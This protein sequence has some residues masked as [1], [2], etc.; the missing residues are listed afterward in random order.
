MCED[1]GIISL[2]SIEKLINMRE[3]QLYLEKHNNKIWQGKNKKWY[4]YVGDRKLIKRTSLRDLED[5]ICEYYFN[6]EEN[7]SF[8]ELFYIWL[9]RKYKTGEICRSTY[10]RYVND[11]NRYFS[12]ATL[13]YLKIRTITEDDID[14]FIRE[15]ISKF[16]LTQKMY[17][18]LRTIIIGT[19]KYAKRMHM[20][21]ISISSFFQDIDIS[22]RVFRP[23]HIS[24]ENAVFNEDEVPLL[25]DYLRSHNTIG[26]MGLIFAFESG[27]RCGELAALKFSDITND[28][29][30]VQRQEIVYKSEESGRQVHEVVE[31][32]KTEMGNRYVY[33]PKG[34]VS[35]LTAIKFQNR[36]SDF[37]FAVNGK[38]IYKTCFNNYLKKACRECGIPERTMHKIRRTYGTTLID[39]NVEDS[40]IM[41]QM[42][43]TDI[44]TTRKYY[45]FANRNDNHKRKQ[46]NSS[47]IF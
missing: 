4:T 39:N 9:D 18:N 42:G 28:I 13:A 47:I 44:S 8:N 24:L 2:E 41:S 5:A 32:T 16:N 31:Y 15:T 26:N 27:V 35:L 34:A 10:D 20:T 43:H 46:I 14:V 25:L 38:R 11:F 3:K 40:L 36:D 22:K 6:I 45:Y 21:T 17:S 33:L 29:L 12:D 7:P 23:N 1:Y 30:H 19:F 37:I